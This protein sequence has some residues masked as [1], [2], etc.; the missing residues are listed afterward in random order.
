MVQAT[1]LDEMTIVIVGAGKIG[2]HHAAAFRQAGHL[3]STVDSHRSAD[4]DQVARV[5]E[6][7]SVD[8]WVVA[9][10][11]ATHLSVVCEILRHQPDARIL[12][13]KPACY[14]AELTELVRTIRRYP[15]ARI[16]V[17]DVYSYSEAVRRFAASVRVHS[18]FDPIRKIT[19]EFTKNR[20][21]DVANGRFVDTQYGE[22]GYEGFHMLSILR[23]ILS[24]DEY[25][26]YL[27]TVPVSVTA[28]MR[29]RTVAA[30]LPEIELYTSSAG[31][32]AFA[33]LA[34]FAFSADV[35]KE[36]IASSTVPYGVDLRYRFADVELDSG[37]HV[38]LVFEPFFGAKADYKNMHAVY[39]HGGDHVRDAAPRPHFVVS[40]NHF[41]GALLTQLDLLR[42]IEEGTT[43]VR[44]SEHRFL[45]ALGW[46]VSTG[47]FPRL[48]GADQFIDIR[49][50]NEKLAQ[51]GS[52]A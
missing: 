26:S 22:A 24:V 15:Q 49:G 48:T 21:F 2:S 41:K 30:K 28:E 20:E 25:Q 16:I 19:V 32:I 45:A 18:E 37:K 43:V 23:S 13:E 3:I 10:P 46:A 5:P 12:L 38:T 29:V 40:G 27:H 8:A 14:P 9:T 36:Y 1:S 51:L 11:T 47:S 39:I 42:Q 34:G 44:P 17:N 6:P 50:N 33:G 7:S 4:W 52:E 31:V 35:V